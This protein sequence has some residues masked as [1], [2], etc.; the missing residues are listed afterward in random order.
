VLVALGGYLGRLAG[1]DLAERCSQGR[2]D[3]RGRAASRRERKRAL[4]GPSSSRWAG[5]ITRVSEGAWQLAERNLREEAGSLRVRVRRI[6]ARLK[7]P[8]GQQEGRSPGHHAAAVTI[9]RRAHGCKARRRAGATG[10]VQR[11][12]TRRATPRAPQATRATR[13]RG[14]RQAPR[15]PPRWRK[16]GQAERNRPPPQEAEHRPRPPAEQAPLLLTA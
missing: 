7:V 8:A 12:G 2:L 3:A 11:N 5:T 1:R 16:T 9:G 10:P 6:E 4:T 14:P 13:E 15:Q